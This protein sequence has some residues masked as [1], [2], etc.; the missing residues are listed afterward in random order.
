MRSID[1][2]EARAYITDYQE[3]DF[4]PFQ[5]SLEGECEKARIPKM[6]FVLLV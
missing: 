1:T 6:R 2:E 3:G 4:L 5:I